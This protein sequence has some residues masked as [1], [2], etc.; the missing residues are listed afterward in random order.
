MYV[1]VPRPFKLVHVTKECTRFFFLFTKEPGY[2][3]FFGELCILSTHVVHVH[4]YTCTFVIRSDEY[5]E[6]E[7]GGRREGGA[8]LSTSVWPPWLVPTPQDGL[9]PLPV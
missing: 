4:C 5:R 8:A 6:S 2:E 9:P 7:S 1:Q 3:Q